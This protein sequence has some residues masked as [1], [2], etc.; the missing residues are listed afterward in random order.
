M[1]EATIKKYSDHFSVFIA[2]LL[3]LISGFLFCTL[4]PLWQN[5]AR[6]L[7]YILYIYRYK[8]CIL[9]DVEYV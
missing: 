4:W 9:N 5:M 3:L 1:D 2:L 6:V 7:G 8:K